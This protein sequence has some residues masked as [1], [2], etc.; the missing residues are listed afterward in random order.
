M[1]Q[2]QLRDKL[3]ELHDE[4]AKTETLDS[5]TRAVLEE[6]SKDIQELLDMPGDQGDHNYGPLTGRLRASLVYFEAS[7]PRLTGA[8]ERAIDAL[9]QMGV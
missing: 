3:N 8:M 2:Q 5:N 6:L 9:V 1:E 7:H 4:L